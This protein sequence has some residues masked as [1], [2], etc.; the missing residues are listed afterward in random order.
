MKDLKHHRNVW[1]ESPLVCDFAIR[2]HFIQ[3]VQFDL[4]PGGGHDRADSII[5]ASAAEKV[6]GV[7]CMFVKPDPFFRGLAPIAKTFWE[8]AVSF[9][10]LS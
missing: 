9:F 7:F 8:G 3:D 1:L 6:V 10:I 2:R 4:I 5:E